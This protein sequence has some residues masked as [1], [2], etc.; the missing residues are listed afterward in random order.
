MVESTKQLA[1]TVNKY[2]KYGHIV[3]NALDVSSIPAIPST[4]KYA[5]ETTITNA[6]DTPTITVSTNGCSIDINACT[7]GLFVLTAEK[8]IGAVPR[9]DSLA[10]IARLN[11][12]NIQANIP[13]VNALGENASLIIMKN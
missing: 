13:P 11:P 9:P 12:H 2:G 4:V 3:P 7:T 5:L 6:V 1:I 8:A 10:N